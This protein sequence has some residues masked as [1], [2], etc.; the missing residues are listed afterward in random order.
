MYLHHHIFELPMRRNCFAK[1][2]KNE[3]TDQKVSYDDSHHFVYF[4]SYGLREV[5]ERRFSYLN[6]KFQSRIFLR[7]YENTYEVPDVEEH[8]QA[9]ADHGE[10][11]EVRILSDFLKHLILN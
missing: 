6:K 5:S 9:M 1:T 2:I 10:E 3:K 8:H 4:V 7:T 11:H